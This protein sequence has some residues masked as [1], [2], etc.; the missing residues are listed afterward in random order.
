MLKSLN[1]TAGFHEI[2]D[3]LTKVGV[4]INSLSMVIH[5]GNQAT[6][7]KD[8]FEVIH[9]KTPSILIVLCKKTYT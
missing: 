1:C 5:H 8:L 7:S 6:I 3:K 2:L 4:V 9:F